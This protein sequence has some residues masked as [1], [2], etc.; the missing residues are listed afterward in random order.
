MPVSNVPA[1]GGPIRSNWAQSVSAVANANE[2]AIPTKVAKAG[3]TMTGGLQIAG[4][5]TTTAGIFA[6]T[7][8]R[9]RALCSTATVTTL[10]L[11]RGIGA[12]AIDPGEDFITFIRG[13]GG[14][15]VGSI[16]IATSSS[17][18]Y[19]TTSDRRLKQATG[20]ADDAVNIVHDIGAAVYRGRWIADD[21]QGQEWVFVNSQDVEPVAPWAVSGA[22]DGVATDADVEAGRAGEVG[23]IIPQQLDTG[24]LVPV[25]LAAVSQLVD[26]VA[27]LEAAG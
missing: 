15:V 4:D 26:R 10:R 23:Q 1:P 21:D 22:P 25:L 17:V 18:A 20:D 24:A 12:G 14:A 27:A 11:A 19:N 7:D 2:T 16:R 13:T 8:G 5:G 6:G 9:V 3:D